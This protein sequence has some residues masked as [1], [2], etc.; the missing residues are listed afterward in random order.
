MLYAKQSED[1]GIGKMGV[2]WERRRG[3]TS[4]KQASMK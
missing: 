2:G 4:K 1:D 3:G